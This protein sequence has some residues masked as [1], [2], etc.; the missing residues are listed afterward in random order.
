MNDGNRSSALMNPTHPGELVREDIEALSWTITEAAARLG[1]GRQ[2]LS[3]LLNGR[4]GVSP[5]MALRL[6]H[7][8][9]GQAEFWMRAQAIYDLAQER[10]RQAA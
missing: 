1:V 6:E 7:N 3:R 8:G 9:I 10:L 5:A 2:R 4:T